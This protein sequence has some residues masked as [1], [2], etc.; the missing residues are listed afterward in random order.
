MNEFSAYLPELFE[1]F[2]PVDVRGMFGGYGVFRDGLMFALAVDDSLYLKAD[3]EN[4]GYFEQMNLARFEYIRSGKVARLG[5]YQ[6]PPE[7]MEDREL[8][9]VWARR[10]YDAALRAQRKKPNSK[11]VTANQ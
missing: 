2:G 8:A 1:L 11:T 9:A 4:A 6:A 10:S 7:I 5:Y 3:A